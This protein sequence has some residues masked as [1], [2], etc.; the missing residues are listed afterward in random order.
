[1]KIT[2][3]TENILSIKDGSILSSILGGALFS[4]VGIL[5]LL[6]ASTSTNQNIA[7]VAGIIFTLAGPVIILL[8]SSIGIDFDKVG[9]Q[10]IYTEKRL[11]GN[12]ISN[13]SIANVARVETRKGY[14]T[15]TNSSSS[16]NSFSNT[17]QI[18]TAQ[19]FVVFKDGSEL[20]IDK[21]HDSSSFVGFNLNTESANATKIA[22]FLGVPF[23]DG[24]TNN[25]G[26][27]LNINLGQGGTI[28][29]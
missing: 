19:S 24:N 10:I 26:S 23:Q 7:W 4:A 13:Y 27:G 12:K 18:P 21:S 16:H 9:G 5:I 1:M 25:T 14:R 2:N 8:G 11:I 17:R 20:S 15:Q 28:Q 29:L 3:Q 6:S 22:T